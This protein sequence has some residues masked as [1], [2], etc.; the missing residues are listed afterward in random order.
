MEHIKSEIKKVK[1]EIE[2]ME[3]S[4]IYKPDHIAAV[5]K[6]KEKEIQALAREWHENNVTELK[7]MQNEVILK[8][9]PTA[10]VKDPERPETKYK[11]TAEEKY[12][13]LSKEWRDI[14]IEMDQRRGIYEYDLNGTPIVDGAVIDDATKKVKTR[15]EQDIE[16]NQK[17]LENRRQEAE[18]KAARTA[19]LEAEVENISNSKGGNIE[20]IN[21]VAGELRAR[22]KHETADQLLDYVEAYHV[23]EPWKNDPDYIAAE[24]QIKEQELLA[25]NSDMLFIDEN[26][27]RPLNIEDIW[28]E[29]EEEEQAKHD[30]ELA[31][32]G[33][34][35]EK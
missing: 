24:K 2:E 13:H 23:R 12:K 21:L 17:L 4:G 19:D 32:A 25:Q 3:K 33:A 30:Q 11:M 22:G 27:D 26:S 29:T 34:K 5:K 8:H 18:I 6:E 7:K 35:N 10:A 16:V 1:K 28:K 31:E 15:T 20:R 9:D 14:Q